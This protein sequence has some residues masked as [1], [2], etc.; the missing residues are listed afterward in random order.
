MKNKSLIYLVVLFQVLVL[1]GMFV[2]AFYPVMVGTPIKLKVLPIDPRDLFRG[3]YVNLNYDFSR[4]DLDSTPNDLDSITLSKL[5]YGDE[6]FVEL[7]LDSTNEFYETVG[8]WK[9]KTKKTNA[10]NALL[11]ATRRQNTFNPWGNENKTILITA[12]I[13]SYF[14]K[15][16]NALSLENKMRPNWSFDEDNEEYIVWSEVYV[17]DEGAARMNDIDFREAKNEE[18]GI[19]NSVL[20][21]TSLTNCYKELIGKM[22]ENISLSEKSINPQV[23]LLE[24]KNA[25]SLTNCYSDPYAKII[26]IKTS[27]LDT[28]YLTTYLLEKKDFELLEEDDTILLFSSYNSSVG[29][30]TFYILDL[31][32]NNLFVSKPFA[33]YQIK[34]KDKFLL[35]YKTIYSN[36]KDSD[37]STLQV[38][39]LEDL[40]SI[41]LLPVFKEK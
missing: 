15:K 36:F 41:T 7:A 27:E 31:N 1:G 33:E 34:E 16:E 10:S 13:E 8:V 25:N 5:T 26:R 39:K 24:L 6:L 23:S 11:K 35:D 18:K 37:T 32:K 3:N 22:Y 30:F 28:L 17:T 29:Y 9:D 21:T 38:H 40:D 12:G 2:K 4:I 19:N 14:T 20:S